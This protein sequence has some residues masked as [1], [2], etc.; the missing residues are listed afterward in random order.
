MHLAGL[1]FDIHS[2]TSYLN[3]Q[4]H[5][6]ANV[7]HV[8]VDCCCVRAWRELWIYWFIYVFQWRFWPLQ[9]RVLLGADRFLFSS[10]LCIH[11]CQCGM[12]RLKGNILFG[13]FVCS[14][15]KWI[16][17][18]KQSKI[19]RTQYMK[20]ALFK[21]FGHRSRQLFFFHTCFGFA[22]F[23]TSFRNFVHVALNCHTKSVRRFNN[24]STAHT[25][26]CDFIIWFTPCERAFNGSKTHA[27]KETKT[28]TTPMNHSVNGRVF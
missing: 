7:I 14:A 6:L 2:I 21:P 12:N 25:S 1:T 24:N 27:I 13:K 20:L 17:K 9:W 5:K 11:T 4:P 16:S 10:S 26:Q 3:F 15:V 22:S 8:C 19:E 28:E 18:V 23:H